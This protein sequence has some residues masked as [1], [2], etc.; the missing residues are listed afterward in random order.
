M[1]LLLESE[2]VSKALRLAAAAHKGQVDK[3]GKDYIGHPIAVAESLDTEEEQTAALLHDTVEDT[4]VTLEGLKAE[5]FSAAV[6][7]AVECLTQ[8]NG[9]PR[10]AYLLRVA[11]N[12]LAIKVKLADLAHNSDLSRL[13]APAE[14]DYARAERYAK[15]A[16]FL[17]AHV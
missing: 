7:R 6:V 13:S 14:K 3:A 17:K 2:S 1:K 16:A 10:E 9:E 8:R 11:A 4:E 12:P 15:E 5:G